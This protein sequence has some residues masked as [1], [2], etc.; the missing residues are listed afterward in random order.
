[1]AEPIENEL[2]REARPEALA[3]PDAQSQHESEPGP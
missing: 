1:M 3:Q 2:V